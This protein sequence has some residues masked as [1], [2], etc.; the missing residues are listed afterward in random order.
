[1]SIATMILAQPVPRK[2]KTRN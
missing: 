1:M 2:G